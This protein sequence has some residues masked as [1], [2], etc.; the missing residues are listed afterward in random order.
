MHEGSAL[1]LI[2]NSVVS[3][4]DTVL[5]GPDSLGAFISTVIKSIQR[6]RVNV[7]HAEAGQSVSFALKRVK[8]AAV[9]KGPSSSLS[10]SSPRTADYSSAT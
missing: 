6:K 4:G 1:I 3:V 10:L 9:R 2:A 5:L 7:L 8:R